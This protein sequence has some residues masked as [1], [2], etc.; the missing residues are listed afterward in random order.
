MFE[1]RALSA[2]ITK[3]L[4]GVDS[5]LHIHWNRP[6]IGYEYRKPLQQYNLSSEIGYAFAS[7]V[8]FMYLRSDH[9]V[10]IMKI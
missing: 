3:R 7:F 9:I 10:L 8:V 4:L 2:N 1:N 6:L 5:R